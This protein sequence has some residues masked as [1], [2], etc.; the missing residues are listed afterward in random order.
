[1]ITLTKKLQIGKKTCHLDSNLE[2]RRWDRLI[3]STLMY[4]L[5]L[6]GM[7]IKITIRRLNNQRTRKLSQSLQVSEN[8]IGIVCL[9]SQSWSTSTKMISLCFWLISSQTLRVSYYSTQ[10]SSNLLSKSRG[11]TQSIR[12]WKIFKI[13]S[14]K[15]KMRSTA[16]LRQDQ[17]HHIQWANQL[18]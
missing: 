15:S 7:T 16:N 10:L 18:S 3:H 4:P 1:M 2:W 14:R 6:E 8:S 5:I 13:S 17:R 11:K 12:K 9:T